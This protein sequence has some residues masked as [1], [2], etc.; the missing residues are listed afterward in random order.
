MPGDAIYS[1]E[2]YVDADPLSDTYGWAMTSGL[3]DDPLV[4]T[5]DVF[6]LLLAGTDKRCRN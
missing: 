2:V 1:E 6:S 5:G 4:V 3:E